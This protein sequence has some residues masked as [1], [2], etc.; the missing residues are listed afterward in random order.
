M[1]F[2][3]MTEDDQSERR[4]ELDEAIEEIEDIR[5]LPQEEQEKHLKSYE[6]VCEEL[7]WKDERSPEVQAAGRKRFWYYNA[8]TA[9]SVVSELREIL[10]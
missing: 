10:K 8:V 6:D 4:Q 1:T 9:N 3:G 5:N 7:G 2:H